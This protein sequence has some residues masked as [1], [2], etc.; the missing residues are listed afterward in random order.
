MKILQKTNFAA[1]IEALRPSQWVKNLALFA[2]VIFNGVL[3]NPDLFEKSVIAFIVYCCLSS[4]AYLINDVA[5][6]DKDRLH[7][8][9]RNRPIA[10][11]DVE[12][13][14]AV[15]L[16]IILI[17]FGLGIS[18]FINLASFLLALFFIVLQFSYSFILKKKAVFDII[19]IAIFFIIRAYAG[20]VATGYHLPI[21]VMLSVIF[22]SLFIASGKRRSEFI[23]TGSKTRAA[24]KGY[25][26]SLL[27]FY[28][29]MFGV[30]TLI[31]Y[32]MFTFYEEPISFEGSL[33][34]F[35][36]DN[37]PNAINRKW[38]MIT[39]F[40]VIFGIMRYGQIIFE[41]QEGERPEK[42]ITTDIPLL[43]S[44]FIW[45]LMMVS[46]IYVL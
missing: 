45:G 34:R 33:H 37:I 30:S 42:V 44:L 4:A 6:I 18:T 17:L 22:L 32:A 21:W 31:T 24:L 46:I 43:I 3:M 16:A 2:S 12:P 26:K 7:P 27:N 15:N 38:Y 28:T 23:N 20:E 35:L 40:P 14:F 8:V 11:G 41:M 25:G 5:D 36:L 9:K 1:V 19:G 13:S 39:L 29:T 10:R